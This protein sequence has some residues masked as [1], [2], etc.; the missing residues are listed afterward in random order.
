[1]KPANLEIA[2]LSSTESS[3]AVHQHFNPSDVI[4]RESQPASKTF[5]ENVRLNEELFAE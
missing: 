4:S 1:M 2:E 3:D 5:Y